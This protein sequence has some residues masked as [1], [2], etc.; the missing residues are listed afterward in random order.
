MSCFFS[1]FSTSKKQGRSFAC[2]YFTSE[3]LTRKLILF[4]DTIQE[5]ERCLL[6][7]IGMIPHRISA[8]VGG[9]GV[10]L[11][12]VQDLCSEWKGKKPQP[13]KKKRPQT[14]PYFNCLESFGSISWVALVGVKWRLNH[15]IH[16]LLLQK[17][18]SPLCSVCHYLDVW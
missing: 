18:H 12:K 17:M 10:F 11:P 2:S 15:G 9:S 5:L 7:D 4:W 8:G 6:A 13:N 14:P 1:E 16:R 3:N